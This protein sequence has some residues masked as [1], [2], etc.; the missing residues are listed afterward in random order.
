MEVL[1]WPFDTDGLYSSRCNIPISYSIINC[2]NFR[3]DSYKHQN[4]KRSQGKIV[5]IDSST[6]CI[7]L[8]MDSDRCITLRRNWFLYENLCILDFCNDTCRAYT[9]KCPYRKKE[10]N[11]AYYSTFIFKV[12]INGFRSMLMT[13]TTCFHATKRKFVKAIVQHVHPCNSCLNLS[14]CLM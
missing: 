10:L 13:Y 5:C 14:Y 2:C 4:N 12:I 3:I 8:N 6:Y 9:L 1:L 11:S 7:R